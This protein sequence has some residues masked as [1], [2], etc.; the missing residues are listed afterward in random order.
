MNNKNIGIAF[1]PQEQFKVLIYQNLKI[2][3]I[4]DFL[5]RAVATYLTP[6]KQWWIKQWGLKQLIYPDANLYIR[7]RYLLQWKIKFRGKSSFCSFCSC[8][9]IG[10]TDMKPQKWSSHR[11]IGVKFICWD[12]LYDQ[13]KKSIIFQSS[14]LK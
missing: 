13:M 3:E 5:W 9:W 8:L 11:C 12:Y 1:V 6:L 2:C 7:S 4:N 14:C 10:I